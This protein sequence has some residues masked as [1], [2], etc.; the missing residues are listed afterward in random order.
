MKTSK[1]FV[2][3]M[4]T[5]MA[6]AGCTSEKPAEKTGKLQDILLKFSD[7]SQATRVPV[8]E[9]TIGGK[10][11]QFNSGWLFVA[12][13]TGSIIKAVKINTTGMADHANNI[14]LL[15]EL[16][17]AQGVQ[18]TGLRAPTDVLVIANSPVTGTETSLQEIE[19]KWADVASQSNYTQTVLLGRAPLTPVNST[20]KTATVAIKPLVARIEI[21]SIEGE[22]VGAYNTIE[23]KVKGIYTNNFY[24]AMNFRRE[25]C[26][27]SGSTTGADVVNMGSDI[28]NYVAGPNYP[29]VLFDYVAGGLPNS[30]Y[31]ASGK[32]YTFAANGSTASYWAYSLIASDVVNAAKMPQI[33]IRLGD[34]ILDKGLPTEHNFSAADSYVSIDKFFEAGTTNQVTKLE[35]GHVYRIDKITFFSSDFTNNPNESFIDVIA[36]VQIANWLDH[37]INTGVQ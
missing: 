31:S 3:I 21:R 7:G 26:T 2:A 32:K 22:A 27:A 11:F 23:F 9:P 25:V 4:A 35:P 1:V 30:A 28:V 20:T 5:A 13:Q 10:K 14:Y 15:S 37:P 8:N 33:L 29:A 36:I 6:L 16:E 18:L 34:M 12:G 17:A 24:P 19:A